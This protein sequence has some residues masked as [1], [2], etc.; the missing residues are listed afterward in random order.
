MSKYRGS[1][2]P[3]IAFT[4]LGSLKVLEAAFVTGITSNILRRTGDKRGD[5]SL[6]VR[7]NVDW[8]MFCLSKEIL[9]RSGRDQ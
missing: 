2:E 5:G 1:E 3:G 7:K 6:T 4:L 9:P 8:D